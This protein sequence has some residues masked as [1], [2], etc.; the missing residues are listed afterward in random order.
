[1]KQ[2][3]NKNPQPQCPMKNVKCKIKNTIILTP[4]RVPVLRLFLI[5]N[6]AFLIGGRA[7]TAGLA[8]SPSP[9]A[10]NY[11]VGIGT[12]SA[13]YV[14]TNLVTGTNATLNLSA[15]F[16]GTN[17]LAVAAYQDNGGTNGLLSPWSN[18]IT[19]TRATAPALQLNITIS[20]STNLVVWT[21][22]GPTATAIASADRQIQFYRPGKTTIA[23]Q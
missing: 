5:I 12:N 1:M 9:S 13:T 18:E 6:F 22:G 21:G 15:L 8:W 23:A 4:M 14:L 20:T 17:Y 7:Q 2:A 11:L 10:T 19:L 3:D 16:P